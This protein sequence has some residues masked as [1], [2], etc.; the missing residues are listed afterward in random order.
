MEVVV[1]AY[2]QSILLKAGIL[3][4]ICFLVGYGKASCQQVAVVTTEYPPFTYTEKGTVEGQ[5]TQIVRSLLDTMKINAEIISYPWAR[6]Y[7]K[8]LKEKN[9]LIYPLVRTPER[10]DVFEW[11]G[12]VA[13]GKTYIY[14]LQSRNDIN[15]SNLDDAKGKSIGVLR[16]SV[17]FSYLKKMEFSKIIEDTSLRAS[18]KK[19]LLGWIDLW[20]VD[21]ATAYHT[22]SLMGYDPRRLIQRQFALNIEL[23]G[24]L[25]FSKESDKDLVESFKKAFVRL[26]VSDKYRQMIKAP[27]PVVR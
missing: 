16:S 13:I 25:A 14:S 12:V 1:F 15:L 18:A 10:E 20:A 26:Q 9:T 24:Y 21:E 7:K 2:R 11:I 17:R 22:L 6:S 23:D 5:A 8:A 19:L 4:V 3:A 27:N